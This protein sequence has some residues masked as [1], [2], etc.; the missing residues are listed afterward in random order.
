MGADGR[1]VLSEL[2]CICVPKV[3]M[4][5]KNPSGG[6]DVLKDMLGLTSF[7]S[8]YRATYILK[9]YCGLQCLL[10]RHVLLKIP[11]LLYSASP[12][13]H[14]LRQT[15]LQYAPSKY[16]S[17]RVLTCNRTGLACTNLVYRKAVEI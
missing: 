4:T 15:F 2:E 14:P 8:V 12:V 13:L 10:R 3:A 11:L 7:T 16:V 17:L 9:G 6:S 5:I 1:E